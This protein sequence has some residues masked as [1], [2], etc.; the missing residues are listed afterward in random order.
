MAVDCCLVRLSSEQRLEDDDEL[1]WECGN[2]GA[3][4]EGCFGKSITTYHMAVLSF[5][6]LR[7]LK[8]ERGRKEISKERV[9]HTY[10]VLITTFRRCHATDTIDCPK[11]LHLSPLNDH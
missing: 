1:V 11:L 9:R 3:G 7:C 10:Y 8:R 6:R 5:R 4:V 2:S